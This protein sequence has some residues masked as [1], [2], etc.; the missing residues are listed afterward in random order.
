MKV[1]E[2]KNTTTYWF[3][4]TDKDQRF[5]WTLL[6]TMEPGNELKRCPICDVYSEIYGC[7]CNED[8]ST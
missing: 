3:D 8:E 6:E 1:K 4:K 5:A 7:F 2:T